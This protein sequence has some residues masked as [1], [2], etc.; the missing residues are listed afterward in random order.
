MFKMENTVGEI[1]AHIRGKMLGA[2]DFVDGCKRDAERGTCY[3]KK[4]IA[5]IE[6]ADMERDIYSQLLTEIERPL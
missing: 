1:K 6:R 3:N 4:Q 2:K 5:L